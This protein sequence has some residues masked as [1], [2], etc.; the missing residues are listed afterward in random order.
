MNADRQAARSVVTERIASH[1]RITFQFGC[2]RG[3]YGRKNFAQ[4]YTRRTGGEK[5]EM[6]PKTLNTNQFILGKCSR[7]T[8]GLSYKAKAALNE[9]E[10]LEKL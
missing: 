2:G 7:T 4:A 6:T 1:A 5:K 10:P 8:K 3:S 9:S